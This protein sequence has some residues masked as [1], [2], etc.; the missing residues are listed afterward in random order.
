MFYRIRNNA[1]YDYSDYKYSDDVLETDIVT[2]AQLDEDNNI[3][4][5][6]DNVL[7]LNPNY[8]EEQAQKRQK[9]FYDDFIEIEDFGCLRKKPK[10]YTSIVEAFNTIFNLV[11]VMGSLP[12]DLIT[13]YT[14]PDFTNKEQC[15]E[16]WLVQ[17][18]FMN[19]AM[20]IAEFN[21]LYSKLLENYNLQ[22]HLT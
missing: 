22:E 11:N 20:S 1:L 8:E 3:V 9:A 10:G 6:E 16:I 12:R 5:I 4:V 21:I 2:Q 17:N 14:K 7:A 19:T 13:I 18:S 15:T